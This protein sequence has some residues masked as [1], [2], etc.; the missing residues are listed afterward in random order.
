MAP[1]TTIP[2]L[3][4]ENIPLAKPI[5]VRIGKWKISVA[6]INLL[7]FCVNFKRKLY[8]N[9]FFLC[10]RF[11]M[12]HSREKKVE[13]KKL[14]TLVLKCSFILTNRSNLNWKFQNLFIIP[15]KIHEIFP[16]PWEFPKIISYT[17]IFKIS[18]FVNL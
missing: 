17:L 11:F 6:I 8:H 9:I 5:T 13:C 7:F 3:T 2:T 1:N 15:L 18:E 14:V 16:I 10:H 4:L 12:A